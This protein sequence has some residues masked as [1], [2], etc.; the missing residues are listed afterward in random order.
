M[1]TKIEIRAYQKQWRENNKEYIKSYMKDYGSEYYNSN[2]ERLKSVRK[3]W[4][5]DNKDLR[6]SY[7]RKYIDKNK[8]KLR[9]S[10]A[11]FR[12]KYPELVKISVKKHNLTTK[13]RFTR[14]KSGATSRG[15]D[16][17]LS[18]EYFNTLINGLCEYCGEGSGYIGIDRIDNDKGYIEGNVC[19]CCTLCNM[20][21]KTLTK[22][23]FIDHVIKISNFQLK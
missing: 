5:S 2:K 15:L 8:E 14:T 7:S 23:Q 11:I 21:K 20:M 22:N 9:N 3:K 13:G 16:F 4:E 12:K 18:I 6:W 17:N 1:R 19:S 10:A